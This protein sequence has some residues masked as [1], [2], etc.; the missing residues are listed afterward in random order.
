MLLKEHY[1]K[2]AFF[3]VWFAGSVDCPA[4]LIQLNQS[5]KCYVLPVK[6]ASKTDRSID[7]A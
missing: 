7:N 5:L 2:G 1:D 6:A 4:P 3:R